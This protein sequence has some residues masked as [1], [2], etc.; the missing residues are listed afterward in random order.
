[1]V[2]E[3]SKMLEELLPRREILKKMLIFTNCRRN[4]W[5]NLKVLKTQ[6]NLFK[7]CNYLSGL[8]EK[9]EEKVKYEILKPSQI[10]NRI[11][12]VTEAS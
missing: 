3:L 8:R 10:K 6:S 12:F 11:L 7:S 2:L 1:M 5:T 9:S 4:N